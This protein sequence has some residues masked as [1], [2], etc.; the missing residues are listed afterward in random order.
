MTATKY[1]RIEVTDAGGLRVDGTHRATIHVEGD[2][3]VVRTALSDLTASTPTVDGP[4]GLTGPSAEGT[5][6]GPHCAV[7]EDWEVACTKGFWHP[8]IGA[9]GLTGDAIVEARPVPLPV[10]EEVPEDRSLLGRKLPGETAR[11]SAVQFTAGATQMLY[12]ARWH[13]FPPSP[14]GMVT[15]QREGDEK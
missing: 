10:T 14:S 11:I 8:W 15:V 7:P 9:P 1:G 12:A 3:A 4:E 2:I 13:E 6:Y 5:W